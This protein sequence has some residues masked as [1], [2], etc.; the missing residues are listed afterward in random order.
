MCEET[1]AAQKH[2][3]LE[4]E[5]Q[6]YVWGGNYLHEA[7]ACEDQELGGLKPHT[8]GILIHYLTILHS[9]RHII[10]ATLVTL[11]QPMYSVVTGF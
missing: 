9:E 6:I 3:S 4:A 1:T 10:V 7:Y 11:S 5:E 2:T 8:Y